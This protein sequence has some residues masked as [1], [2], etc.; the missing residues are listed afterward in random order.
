MKK[1]KIKNTY[2]LNIAGKPSQTCD[3]AEKQDKYGVSPAR[4]N[5]IK[6]KLLIK[7]GD[8]VKV[9]SPLFFDKSN[10]KNVFLSPVSGKISGIEFG[11]RRVVDNIV[12]ESDQK[13]EKIELFTKHNLKD[14]SKLKAE[15]ISDLIQKGGLW[16]VFTA[17]PFQMTP[18]ATTLPPSIYVSLD[19]DE[20]F[21]PQSSV[22]S[23]GC[24]EFFVLGLTALKQLTTHV[25]V[26]ISTK[27]A[28]K[29]TK[30]LEH[31]THRL[32]GA[33]PANNPGV[34]LYYNKKD[35][36]ENSAWGVSGQDVIRIGQLLAEGT[37]PNEKVV[38]VAGQP[39]SNPRHVRI[40]EGQSVASIADGVNDKHRVI[41]GGVLTGKKSSK[42]GYVSY[43]EYAVN[44]I[45]D[46]SEQEMFTFFRPGF[47]KPTYGRTYLSALL[48]KLDWKMTTSLNGGHRAC[49]ACG[50]CADVCPVELKPQFVMKDLE[51][52]DIE[53]PIEQ[54][55]LDCVSCGLCTYVCPSKIELN[56]IFDESRK[57]IAKEAGL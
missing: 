54:G 39:L 29:E 5:N 28:L 26:G 12:I 4:L 55:F 1:L 19:N 35:A 24:S 44:V 22:Y 17:Y 3:I 48:S 20:P 47:D 18:I 52:G 13:F 34:F 14:V 15:S 8:Q 53:K 43:N 38:A 49:I 10:D 23:A 42:D 36:S 40:V 25:N 46:G 21:L 7:E 37:Y 2:D 6:V 51:A 50:I 30:V 32:D 16:S 9:G 57:K 31:V 27:T 33:Y 56:Y 11:P 41:A 45:Q